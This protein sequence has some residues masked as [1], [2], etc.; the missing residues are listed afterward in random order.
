LEPPEADV[1]DQPPHDPQAPILSPR[2]FRHIL[3]EGAVMGG[4]ALTG[5]FLA[6]GAA[7]PVRA[8]TLAFH[9]L[10]FAQL[11]HALSCRSETRGF[12]AEI[13]RPPSAKLYATLAGSA[14]VQ[15]AAQM[16]PLTRRFLRLAPLGAGDVLAIAGI[17]VGST[18]AN[19]VLGR[20][21]RDFE[22]PL[23]RKA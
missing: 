19:E 11:L 20:V 9:G 3:R 16:F 12:A 15:V 13:G 10:T 2:D 23:P 14:A 8:G 18:L 22:Q 7:N 5:Y 1:L 21:L 4:A 17:A 6:G